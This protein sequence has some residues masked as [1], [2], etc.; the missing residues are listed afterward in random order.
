MNKERYER[1]TQGLFAYL[2]QLEDLI[3]VTLIPNI[4]NYDLEP[5]VYEKKRDRIGRLEST[6]ENVKADKKTVKQISEL[7]GKIERHIQKQIRELFDVNVHPAV[8]GMNKANTQELIKVLKRCTHRVADV[9]VAG[10]YDNPSFSM[11]IT[12]YRC[13]SPADIAGHCAALMNEFPSGA[14]AQHI[15]DFLGVTPKQADNLY[16][17]EFVTRDCHGQPELITPADA[18]TELRALMKAAEKAT[19]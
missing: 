5:P 2:E 6:L 1:Q 7:M 8:S 18:I 10:Q 3:H 11:C 13:G 14:T 15:L 19:P 17:G 9:S 4:E 16:W 12:S